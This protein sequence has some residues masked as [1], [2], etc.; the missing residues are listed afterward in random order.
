MWASPEKVLL[1]AF[2]FL[3]FLLGGVV[4]GV[5][6]L[7]LPTITIGLLS[8]AMAPASAAALLIAPSLATNVWQAAGRRFSAIVS[9]VWTMMLAIC[10]GTFAT[11]G[12]IT[13]SA[14]GMAAAALGAT[15]IVYG[16]VGLTGIR[17]AVPKRH[18]WWMSPLAGLATG[19]V[20]GAT[21]IFVL[22]AV[23]YLQA[24]GFEKDELVQVLGL[25]FLVST[26][27]LA[28]ALVGGGAFSASLAGGSALALLPALVGMWL[29]QK[30]RARISASLFKTCF[31]WGLILLGAHLASR[32][33]LA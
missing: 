5:I 10:L 33:W 23:P 9:R 8:L 26:I 3:A 18:E 12:I 15:L 20:T 19:A 1:S 28:F 6:G 27:A 29:G 22:P 24:L 30:L 17:P 16:I 11:A 2:I 32:P 21:G 14:S 4:K 7:G 13:G 31:F 25:S